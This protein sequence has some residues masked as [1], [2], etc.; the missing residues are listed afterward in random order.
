MGQGPA[1]ALQLRPPPLPSPGSCPSAPSSLWSAPVAAGPRGLGLFFLLM[2]R[3]LVCVACPGFSLAAS[4]WG[5]R[6]P[7]AP[8]GA[9]GLRR[10]RVP[11]GRQPPPPARP[12]P[13]RVPPPRGS[14]AAAPRWGARL[15]LPGPRSRK[16][17]WPGLVGPGLR[18]GLGSPPAPPPGSLPPAPAVAGPPPACHPAWRV[19]GAD[20]RGPGQARPGSWWRV[21]G[22]AHEAWS[23][24]AAVPAPAAGRPWL[25]AGLPGPWRPPAPP[26]PV[27][28]PPGPAARPLHCQ[29]AQGLLTYSGGAWAPWRW[30]VLWRVKPWKGGWLG[31]RPGSAEG[32]AAE[33]TV[34]VSEGAARGEAS[35]L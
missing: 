25:L 20:P 6:A 22:G 24:G 21:G 15:A 26:Q 2:K 32:L 4:L 11:A 17:P 9:L 35:A 10:A 13:R 29:R 31:A 3:R 14:E 19:L 33:G 1:G 18:P 16:S 23:P 34:P 28:L 5:P 8:A 30:A 12:A 7:P 27:L